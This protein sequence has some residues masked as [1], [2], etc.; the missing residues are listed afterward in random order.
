MAKM[1]RKMDLSGASKPKKERKGGMVSDSSDS[2]NS[3]GEQNM[4]VDMKITKSIKK[5]KPMSR[6]YY[7]ALKKNLR[8]SIKDGRMPD[9]SKLDQELAKAREEAGM[10]D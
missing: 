8:R 2:D 10:M 1:M 7:Q 5:K 9:M 6:S 3:E 4:E